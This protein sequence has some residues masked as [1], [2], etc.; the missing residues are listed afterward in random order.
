MSA[1]ANWNVSQKLLQTKNCL[2]GREPW[3]SG[4][5]RRLMF[6]MSWVRIP[7][8]Y[9]GWTYFHIPICC[10]ICNVFFKRWKINE[11]EA[12]V[13]PF[14]KNCLDGKIINCKWVN[15]NL[16][17]SEKSVDVVLGNSNRVDMMVQ[18]NPLK[19]LWPPNIIPNKP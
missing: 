1:K 7:A 6:Q 13:V 15:I 5:G 14:L 11:K 17:L 18:M 9:T 16:T 4:Y 8:P 19:L 2:E 10:K 12:G 3:S